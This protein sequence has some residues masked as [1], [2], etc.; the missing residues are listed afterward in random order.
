MDY[1]LICKGTAEIV[2]MNVP[3]VAQM[4]LVRLVFQDLSLVTR[5]ATTPML[6]Q[7]LPLVPL[8]DFLSLGTM[9]LLAKL[10]QME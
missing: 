2:S 8:E 10:A 3:L 9:E 6:M 7:E 5:D 1:T 4:D